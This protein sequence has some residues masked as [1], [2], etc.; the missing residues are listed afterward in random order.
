MPLSL[1]RFGGIRGSSEPNKKAPVLATQRLRKEK[2]SMYTD[3][4]YTVNGVE[5]AT[6]DESDED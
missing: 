2:G 5:Y 3:Y 1:N 6:V 4:G